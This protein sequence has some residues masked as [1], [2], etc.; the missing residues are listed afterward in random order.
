MDTTE[1][2]LILL[3]THPF[4]K[5]IQKPF[6]RGLQFTQCGPELMPFLMFLEPQFSPLNRENNTLQDPSPFRIG[7]DI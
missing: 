4:S 7:F 6:P 1:T 2:D 5:L 3:T